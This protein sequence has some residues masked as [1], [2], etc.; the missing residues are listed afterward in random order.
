[1]SFADLRRPKHGRHSI[2]VLAIALM[3]TTE[4]QSAAE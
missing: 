2:E 3:R 4:R 1:M